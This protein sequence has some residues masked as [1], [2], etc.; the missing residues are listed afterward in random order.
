MMAND[1]RFEMVGVGRLR[2]HPEALMPIDAEDAAAIERSIREVG[3]LTPL[4]V[5]PEYEILD[6]VN[7]WKQAQAAGVEQVPCI[8]RDADP[9]VVVAECLSA[10]RKTSTGT[11]VLV[12]L[13]ANWKRVKWA[14]KEGAE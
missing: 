9:K 12:Y 14:Q 1:M 3:V 2:A 4:I 8:I 10:R 5:N 7:R 11:R 6:G 13:E